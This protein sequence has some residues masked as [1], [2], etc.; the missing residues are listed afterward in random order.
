MDSGDY[1]YGQWWLFLWAVVTISMDSG[2]YFYGQWWLFLW[3][4]V[5][6]SVDSDDFF[7]GQWW[8]FLWV[9][10]IISMGSGNSFYGQ[11]WLFL[12]AVVIISMGSGDYFYGQWWLFLWTVMTISMDS[13]DYFYGQSWS[14][15]WTVVIISVDGGDNFY[16]RWWLF[17]WTVVTISV[18]GSTRKAWDWG[19]GHNFKNKTKKYTKDG[20]RQFIRTAI[21]CWQSS[22]VISSCWAW[23]TKLRTQKLAFYCM[24]ILW[25]A[26]VPYA[27]DLHDPVPGAAGLLDIMDHWSSGPLIVMDQMQLGCWSSWTTDHPVHWWLW[28]RRSWAIYRRGPDVAAVLIVMNHWLPGR[29]SQGVTGW[30]VG[31]GGG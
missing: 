27:C 6:I 20:I 16:G 22:I 19:G 23:K 1:F 9:M 21:I 15:L 18:G 17:L 8:L 11:W 10:V 5:T 12:W 31:G 29:K 26:P 7:Y 4:V 25:K 28:T 2:D 14:F 24:L 3:A 13:D 30:W